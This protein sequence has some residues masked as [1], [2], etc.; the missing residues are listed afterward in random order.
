M[1]GSFSMM[2]AGLQ[3]QIEHERQRADE[4][5]ALRKYRYGVD[6]DEN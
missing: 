6:K 1:P 3:R 2:T 5:L 4:D